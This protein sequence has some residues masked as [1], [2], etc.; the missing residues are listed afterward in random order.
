M[1]LQELEHDGVFHRDCLKLVQLHSDAVDYAKSGVYVP[2]TSIPRAIGGFPDFLSNRPGGNT[3]RTDGLLGLLF[4]AVEE[5][6]EGG[7]HISPQKRKPRRNFNTLDPD[8]LLSEAIASAFNPPLPTQLPPELSSKVSS[9]LSAFSEELL[10]IARHATIKGE[11]PTEAELVAG[12]RVGTGKED[13]SV[14][15]VV[16]R[17][18]EQTSSL[19]SSL[20]LALERHQKAHAVRHGWVAWSLA[21]EEEATSRDVRFGVRTF[22]LVSLGVLLEGLK[23]MEKGYL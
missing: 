7:Q 4:R 1:L 18:S 6:I 13:R 2:Q 12:V 17:M 8:R 23:E 22:A 9:L 20:R 21:V 3:I 11:E 16:R 5:K 15:N 19:F 14:A 10:R